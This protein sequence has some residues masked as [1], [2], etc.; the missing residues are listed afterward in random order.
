MVCNRAVS[1]LYMLVLRHLQRDVQG[2]ME[3]T[4]QQHRRRICAGNADWGAAR[5]MEAAE[6]MMRKKQT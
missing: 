6:L 3:Y 2:A 5:P 1:P 4:F